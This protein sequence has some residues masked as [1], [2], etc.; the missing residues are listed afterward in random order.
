M[1]SETEP[2]LV[3]LDALGL[4]HGQ[5]TTLTPSV[6]L[7]EI[8]LGGQNYQPDPE[9]PEVTLGVSRTTTGYALRLRFGVSLNGP[10]FRCLEDSSSRMTVDVRE[11]DQPADAA[12]VEV[13][14]HR[15]GD[16]AADEDDEVSLD[17]DLES[18]YVDAGQLDLFGWARDAL[19]LTLPAQL[20]CQGDCLGLC[21]YCGESLN[22]ADPAAHD[23]GQN[24]DPRWAKLRDLS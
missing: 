4:S 16:P 20:L 6:D 13:P 21:S 24:L 18:P 10:C 9:R 11:V 1:E 3:D 14:G 17:A 12:V 7:G 19:I 5:A 22:G 8:T 2:G 23:H 15:P